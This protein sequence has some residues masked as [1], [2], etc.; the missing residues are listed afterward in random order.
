MIVVWAN[1]TFWNVSFCT[2]T[3]RTIIRVITNPFKWVLIQIISWWT[4]MQMM[5]GTRITSFSGAGFIVTIKKKITAY[6]NTYQREKLTWKTHFSFIKKGKEQGSPAVP[7][8]YARLFSS[9]H[10]PQLSP[11]TSK[12]SGLVTVA[13]QVSLP[14]AEIL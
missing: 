3:K 11:S 2:V 10:K 1:V 9:M 8:S 7:P 12:L 4:P 5:L 14:V 13:H 6:C